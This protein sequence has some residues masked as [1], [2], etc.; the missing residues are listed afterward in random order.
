MRIPVY[1][2]SRSLLKKIS[3]IDKRG[4]RC[5]YILNL[6]YFRYYFFYISIV[7]EIFLL[8]GELVNYEELKSQI[9]EYIHFYSNE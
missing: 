2:F 5:D 4:V 9:E 3:I 1:E 6:F 8:I 7:F